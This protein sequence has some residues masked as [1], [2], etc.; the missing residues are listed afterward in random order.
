MI[1]KNV[2]TT[3]KFKFNKTEQL[4]MQVTLIKYA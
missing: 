2:K 1:L 3:F 4:T